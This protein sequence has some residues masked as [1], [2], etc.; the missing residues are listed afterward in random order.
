MPFDPVRCSLSDPDG[1]KNSK[2]VEWE[3]EV[4]PEGDLITREVWCDGEPKNQ[5]GP[6]WQPQPVI[7]P[8]WPVRSQGEVAASGS[9]LAG[10]QEYWSTAGNRLRDSAKWRPLAGARRSGGDGQVPAGGGEGA[11]DPQVVSLGIRGFVFG[12]IMFFFFLWSGGRSWCR[13]LMCSTPRRGGWL[14]RPLKGAGPSNHSRTCICRGGEV[15]Y[16]SASIDDHRGNNL[17]GAVAG[18]GDRARPGSQGQAVRRS[19]RAGWHA[20]RIACHS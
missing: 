10:V 13:T 5:C 15:P 14:P 12:G 20:F 2:Q 7:W 3:V 1:E 9:P 8:A 16:R 17:D 19:G 6:G 4:R 18:Q 11:E